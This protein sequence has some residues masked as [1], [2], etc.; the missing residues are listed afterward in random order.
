MDLKSKRIVGLS[1]I[2]LLLAMLLLYGRIGGMGYVYAMA[3]G[4]LIYIAYSLFLGKIPSAVE[5]VVQRYGSKYPEAGTAFIKA[6]MA[7]AGLGIVFT[8]GFIWGMFYLFLAPANILY[9]DK[10]LLFSMI[11]LPFLALMQII[12]GMV[13]TVLGIHYIGYAGFVFIV[14]TVISSLLFAGMLE[15]YGK[16]AANLLQSVKLQHFY[17]LLGVLPGVLVGVLGA[18]CFMVLL[19]FLHRNDFGI[20]SRSA[21]RNIE[22]PGVFKLSGEIAVHSLTEALSGCAMHIPLFVL[23]L[24]SFEEISKGNYLV[25]SFYGGVLP[26]I[27]ILWCLFDLGLVACKRRL[28]IAYRNRL[29]ARVYYRELKT[30]LCYALLHSALAAGLVVALHK[31]FLAVWNLQTSPSLMH[32]TNAGAIIAFLGFF[33]MV[34]LDLL[35]YRSL[36]REAVFSAIAGA[37]AAV[38]VC[39][40]CT[41]FFGAGIS[42]YVA[43][44]GAQCLV[45][46]LVAAW[47]LSRVA[48]IS[49]FSVFLRCIKGLVYTGILALVLWLLQTVL[50]TPLG[51]LATLLICLLTGIILFWAGMSALGI[52]D[53]EELEHFPFGFILKHIVGIFR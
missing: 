24:L 17:V 20:F 5:S 22:S 34:L 39:L 16:K 33:A 37:L 42:L 14:C 31:S 26:V 15:D 47:S 1:H 44:I 27:G 21:K 49:Y 6:A 46:G 40:F 41:K 7:Y 8:I 48:G 29:E 43:G 10:L 12:K 36:Q 53:R 35:R 30:T 28:Y 19:M 3:A 32:L 38:P 45:T 4:E 18:I 25:G 50:F 52:F 51:G 2:V 13:Q 9:V 11:L 23:L